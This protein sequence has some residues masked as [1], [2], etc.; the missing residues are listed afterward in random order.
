[1]R[2]VGRRIR[3][4]FLRRQRRDRRVRRKVD[5]LSAVKLAGTVAANTR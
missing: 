3:D 1:M 4:A 2:D 5:D